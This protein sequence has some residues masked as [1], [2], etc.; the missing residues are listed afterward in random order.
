MAPFLIH[1]A[2]TLLFVAI[3]GVPDAWFHPPNSGDAVAAL[4]V[5]PLAEE[6]GWRGFLHPRAVGR[7]GL[8]RGSLLV[9]LIWGFWHLAY[10]VTPEK[11]SFDAFAF[12][13]TMVELPLYSLPIAW[14]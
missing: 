11:G 4:L 10:S 13:M 8:V 6:F 9:G 14:I 7:F 5:F 12:G 2:A 3:G 1:L